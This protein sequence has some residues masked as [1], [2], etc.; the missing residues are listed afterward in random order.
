MGNTFFLLY[1]EIKIDTLGK[2]CW[3]MS[4]ILSNQFLSNSNVNNLKLDTRHYTFKFSTN[5]GPWSMQI[6][7]KQNRKNPQLSEVGD[8]SSPFKLI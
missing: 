8:F 2:I 7:E 5:L 3:E 4:L 6:I 1:K